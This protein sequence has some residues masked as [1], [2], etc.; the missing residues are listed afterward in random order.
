MA[1]INNIV[2]VHGFWADGSCYHKIIPTLLAEGYEVIAVQNPLT[3]LADDVAAT[4]RALA[5]IEGNCILVGHSW[6]GFVISEAGNDEKVAGLVYLAAL[7]PDNG[8]STIDLLGKYETPAALQYMQERD[9]FIWLSLEGI[10]KTFA[11]D[12]PPEECALIN[13]TQTAPSASLSQTKANSL[14]AWK[15]KPSWYI[16]ANNDLSVSPEYQ[17]DASKRIKATT[18]V[19]EC[20]HVP[21]L[22]HP[23][24]VLEIIRDAATNS[25]S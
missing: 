18:T 21:M 11:G 19:L 20:S 13:A 8:E 10:Q 5:R 12:L 3:S 1:K 7:A 24:E 15:N 22:S 9:G 25:L 4:K 14:G 17:H 2:L 16:V 23:Q 6:G